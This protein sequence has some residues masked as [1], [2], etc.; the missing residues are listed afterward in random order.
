MRY[1]G[2]IITLSVF[3]FFCSAVPAAAESPVPFDWTGSSFQPHHPSIDALAAV[4]LD[5]ET[6]TVLYAHNRHK[7]LPPASLVKLPV[8]YTLL[9]EVDRGNLDVDADIPIPSQAWAQNAPPHSSLMFL[10]PGQRASLNDLLLGLAVTSGNDAAVGAAL[11]LD[12]SVESFVARVNQ[13]LQEMGLQHTRLVEPS[14]YSRDNTT[15]A[16]EF[17][18]FAREYVRSFPEAIERYH[19]VRSFGYPRAENLLPG[20]SEQVIMQQNYNRLLWIMPDADGLKTGTTPSAG[21]NLA[22]TAERNGRRLISVVLGV[23]AGN[24][25]EGNMKRAEISRDLLEYGFREYVA[26]PPRLPDPGTVRMYGTAV[27]SM[28]LYVDAEWAPGDSAEG[29]GEAL[30]LVLPRQLAGSMQAVY[31]VPRRLRGPV[32][33]GTQVGRVVF[34]FGEQEVFSA[35]VRAAQTAAKGPWWR[36]V[37]DWFRL[38]FERLQGTDFPPNS[39]DL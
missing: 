22:A 20:S 7:V 12:D 39:E 36:R 8:M 28:D 23:Q 9:E 24:S 16:D 10:G 2:S 29:S 34:T 37:L 15:T 14:G 5:A 31:E 11:L 35:P 38:W 19:S 1:P 21:Y 4:L 13:M 30:P 32:Q 25:R 26:M 6:G 33:A 27:A 17:A 18:R 3:L